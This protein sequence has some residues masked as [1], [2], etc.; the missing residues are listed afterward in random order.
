MAVNK[1]STAFTFTFA[2]IMVVVVGAILAFLSISLKPMQE[3][4]AAD[5][6]KMNILFKG[7]Y[8]IFRIY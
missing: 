4:N 5:K 3:A 2:I 1:N 7:D 8:M 6:K